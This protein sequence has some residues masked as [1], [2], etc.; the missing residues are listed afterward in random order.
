MVAL[1]YCVVLA[2]VVGMAGLAALYPLVVV[3]TLLGTLVAMLVA[4]VRAWWRERRARLP[5]R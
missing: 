5:T 2:A 3:A 4:G 1:A